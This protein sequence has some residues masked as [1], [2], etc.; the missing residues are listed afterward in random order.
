MCDRVSNMSV[1]PTNNCPFKTFA[2]AVIKELKKMQFNLVRS[3]ITMK[4]SNSK[5]LSDC[6]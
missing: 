1:N 2:A 5:Y 6:A 4:P 3:G